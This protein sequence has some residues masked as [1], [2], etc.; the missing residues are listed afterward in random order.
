ME[1]DARASSGAEG[2]DTLHT[3]NVCR[4]ARDISA[5]SLFFDGSGG[6]KRQQGRCWLVY[7]DLSEMLEFAAHPMVIYCQCE[8]VSWL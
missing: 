7:Y 3:T 2:L 1:A 6:G 5:I 4:D 8:F